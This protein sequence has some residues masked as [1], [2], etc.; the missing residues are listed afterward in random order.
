MLVGVQRQLDVHGRQQG[1][2][3]RL[4]EDDHEVEE[5]ECNGEEDGTASQQGPAVELPEEEVRGAKQH[6]EDEVSGQHVGHKTNG[7]RHWTKDEGGEEFDRYHDYVKEWWQT[8][9]TALDSHHVLQCCALTFQKGHQTWVGSWAGSVVRS[10]S[11][12]T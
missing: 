5:G 3:V 11:G 12:S 2:D 7:Q 1:E 9:R 4:Q 10:M 6:D 8:W